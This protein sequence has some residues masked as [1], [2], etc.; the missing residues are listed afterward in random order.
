M[1]KR[2]REDILCG[3]EMDWNPECRQ[4]FEVEVETGEIMEAELLVCVEI[5]GKEY[6]VY[7]LPGENGTRDVLASYVRQDEEG[8]DMLVNIDHPEDKKKI[9]DF[10]LEMIREGQHDN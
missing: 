8:F 3:L 10:V 4:K 5:D 2:S 9:S 7:T 1:G 6:A